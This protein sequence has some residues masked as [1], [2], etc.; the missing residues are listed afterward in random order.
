MAAVYSLGG[1]AAC[2]VEH[3]SP[4]ASFEETL[5]DY[6]DTVIPG[7]EL[8]PGAVELGVLQPIL[9]EA[10]TDPNVQNFLEE[11]VRWLNEEARKQGAE[12]FAGLSE[13]G[14]DQVV[15]AAEAA[16]A[17]SLEN[18]FFRATRYVVF[19]LYY[20]EP[21]AW[22]AIGYDGPPQPVGFPDYTAPPARGD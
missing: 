9:E 13:D 2:T 14:R 21:Q 5:A 8:S 22:P 15:A 17:G 20:M 10:K 3:A 7:D 12:D 1:T 16:K 19:R 4:A 11:G 6:L 18:E